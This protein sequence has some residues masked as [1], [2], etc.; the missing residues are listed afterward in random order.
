MPE[1]VIQ[2]DQQ[3]TVNVELKVGEVT[4]TVTVQGT[5][6]AVETRVGTLNTAIHSKMINDLPLNGRNVMQLLQLT[7]GTLET[8]GTQGTFRRRKGPLARNCRHHDLCQW[9][10][11]NS[12]TFILDGGL[13]EDSYT[14]VANVLPTRCNRRVR[15]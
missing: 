8:T 1:F 6:V 13:H 4:E 12:T 2:V 3:A 15:V 10:N 7:P 5:P 9:R 11:P 14:E